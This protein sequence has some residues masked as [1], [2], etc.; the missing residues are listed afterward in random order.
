MSTTITNET[1]FTEVVLVTQGGDY[2]MH[3]DLILHLKQQQLM[4][5]VLFFKSVPKCCKCP[6]FLESGG[7]SELSLII[8]T[9]SLSIR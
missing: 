7:K 4:H 2:C 9:T 8:L 3:F 6:N 1:V 5:Q